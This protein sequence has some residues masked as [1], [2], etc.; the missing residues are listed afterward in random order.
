MTLD[1][2]GSAG[3]ASREMRRG[4]SLAGETRHQHLLVTFKADDGNGARRAGAACAENCI[5]IAVLPA[6]HRVVKSDGSISGYRWGVERK[7]RS[8][9]NTWRRVA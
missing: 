3:A 5:A 1:L 4:R 2:R 8:R 6:C 9:I 7:R